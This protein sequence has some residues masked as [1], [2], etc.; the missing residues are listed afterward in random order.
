MAD[1][2]GDEERL[3]AVGR[4][5]RPHGLDGAF[6]VERASDDPTRYRVGAHLVVDGVETE[7]VASRR[8]GGGRVA[9]RLDKTVSRGA[10]L[11]VRRSELPA[12]GPDAWYAFELEGLLVEDE[13]GAPF[14]RVTGVHPGAANDNIELDNGTLI[15]LIDDALVSVDPTRGR[16]VVRAGFLA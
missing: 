5:G 8:V 15:P 11:A 9:I 13:T 1:R 10:E 4:V 6:V 3:I 2:S 7:V 16:I 14:G 12:Q